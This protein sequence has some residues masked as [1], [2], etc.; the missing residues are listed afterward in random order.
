MWPKPWAEC[1]AGALGLDTSKV[2]SGKAGRWK[3]QRQKGPR[4][5]GG[6]VLGLE[7]REVHFIICPLA[8]KSILHL[9]Y[10][11]G[12]LDAIKVKDY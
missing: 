2:G 9:I 3:G 12:A 11:K 7:L 8:L 5:G 6:V 4:A 10:Q 1:K